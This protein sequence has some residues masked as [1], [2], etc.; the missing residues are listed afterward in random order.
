PSL[1]SRGATA[2]ANFASSVLSMI[3]PTAHASGNSER[4][5]P[6]APVVA[7]AH[8]VSQPASQRVQASNQPVKVTS[9]DNR[10]AAKVV[11]NHARSSRPLTPMFSGETVTVNIGTLRA[12]KSVTIKFQ[13]TVNSP[14]NLTLLNPARVRNQ[15]TVSGSNFAS[16][17]T[18]DPA[19]GGA[20]D[21]TDTP[22]DL[23]DTSTSLISSLNPSN[24]GD[25]VTFTA[26]VSETPTQASADPTGT[27][28][29]IDTSN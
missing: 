5:E 11:S 4:I 14:P 12:G 18:D 7:T 29:F 10:K 25:Q 8:V 2:V 22:V 19:V 1:L 3:E 28:D 24:F 20:S 21:P 26:T 17:L 6:A 27:V 13:V 16:V 15:G 9:I 23:F